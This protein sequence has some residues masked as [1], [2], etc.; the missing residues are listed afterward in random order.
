MKKDTEMVTPRKYA[1]RHKV[2]YTTVMSWLRRDLVPGV[3]KEELPYGGWYYRIP[4]DAPL[5]ELKPGRPTFEERLSAIAAEILEELSDQ[6]VDFVPHPPAQDSN[7]WRLTYVTHSGEEKG[8]DVVR[9]ASQTDNEMKSQIL[10]KLG[11]ADDQ[12]PTKPARKTSKKAAKKAA[13][14]GAGK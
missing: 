3:V 10:A 5:P 2:H 14:K 8:V 1:E 4:V 9:R 7:D 12:E 13:K 6:Y 11:I